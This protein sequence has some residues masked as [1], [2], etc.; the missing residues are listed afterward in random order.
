[1][2]ASWH[3]F[4][5][6]APVT[7]L[8]NHPRHKDITHQLLCPQD[9]QSEWVQGETSKSFVFPTHLFTPQQHP[10]QIFTQCSQSCILTGSREVTLHRANCWMKGLGS[11]T[12]DQ[13]SCQKENSREAM[14]Y[15][16]LIQD[17]KFVICIWTICVLVTIASL[18]TDRLL[19]FLKENSS[20]LLNATNLVFQIIL[21]TV[22]ERA[23]YSTVIL[24]LWYMMPLSKNSDLVF[25]INRVNDWNAFCPALPFAFHST[26]NSFAVVMPRKPMSHFCSEVFA[27]TFGTTQSSSSEAYWKRN[28][29]ACWI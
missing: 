12:S 20:G 21:S 18:I 2:L 6:P 9:A 15:L 23:S 25:F 17:I 24:L 3:F 29:N 13:R 4:C 7:H 1:M 26:F 27:K 8:C 22:K 19:Q 28:I 5:A 11:F 10:K 16:L 14:A